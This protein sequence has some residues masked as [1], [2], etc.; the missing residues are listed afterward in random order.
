MASKTTTAAILNKIVNIL[1]AE[2]D[3]EMPMTQVTVFARI[4]AAGDAGIDQ[5]TLQDD[6]QMSSASM[7]RTVQALSPIHYFKDRPGLNVV[8]RIF[9]PQDNRKRA[10]R[11][12][13]K[14]QRLMAK[15]QEVLQ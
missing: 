1:N 6:L 3:R 2:M 14:G 4:A 11:L 12:N 9:D 7:S 5:G 8:E 13:A 15:L 10:L